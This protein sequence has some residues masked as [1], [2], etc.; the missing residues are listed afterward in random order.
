MVLGVRHRTRRKTATAGR[1][2]EATR[3][4]ALLQVLEH[5]LLVKQSCWA[6]KSMSEYDISV[7]EQSLISAER[8]S[9][10]LFD[11]G[12]DYDDDDDDDSYD[13]SDD[14]GTDQGDDDDD[15]NELKSEL[16]DLLKDQQ[17]P[18]TSARRK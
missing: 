10:G 9:I 6:S 11:S 3:M 13:A 7:G 18:V 5:T 8:K 14:D 1:A 4:G 16:A 17:L 2:T 15:V 12:G